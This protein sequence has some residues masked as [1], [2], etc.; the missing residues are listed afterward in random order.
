MNEEDYSPN[1]N[2]NNAQSNSSFP[3]NNVVAKSS[4]RLTSK[5]GLI[6]RKTRRDT[7]PTPPFHHHGGSTTDVR[8]GGQHLHLVR[9]SVDLTTHSAANMAPNHNRANMVAPGIMTPPRT[10]SAPVFTQAEIPTCDH[11]HDGKEVRKP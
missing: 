9:S 2:Y 5:L 3:T 11:P 8:G 1:N 4:S 6:K 7:T 10:P